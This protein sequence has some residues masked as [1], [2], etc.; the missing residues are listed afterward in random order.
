MMFCQYTLYAA[1]DYLNTLKT[2]RSGHL[3]RQCYFTSGGKAG[4]LAHYCPCWG[5]VRRGIKS[6]KA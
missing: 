5:G 4:I 3:V 2:T 6:T 1:C